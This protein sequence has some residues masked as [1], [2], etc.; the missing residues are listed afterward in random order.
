MASLYLLFLPPAGGLDYLVLN[1][2]AANRFQMWDGDVEYTRRLM[3]VKRLREKP[4]A[5]RWLSERNPYVKAQ[6]SPLL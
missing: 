4:G 6:E 2:I 1:H 3:Q 5:A